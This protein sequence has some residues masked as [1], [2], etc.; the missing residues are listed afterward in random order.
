[1]NV[2]S[3]STLLFDHVDKSYGSLQVLKDFHG[4]FVRGRIAAIV[5]PNGAGKTTLLRIAAGLQSPTNGAVIKSGGLYYGGFDLLPRKGCVDDLRHALGLQPVR[6]GDRK[7]SV[8]SRGELQQA[9]LDAAF[10][11]DPEVLLLDEPWTALEPDA[12]E[13]LNIRMRDASFSHIIVCSSHDLDEV[14]RVADDVVFLAH[15]A[16]T[17]KRRESAGS[18]DRADLLNTYR[19]SKRS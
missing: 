17:W 13:A 11:L 18:F 19:E 4:T 14:V 9:G 15:G 1:M 2:A 16:A 10:D 8:L 3:L 7:L 5:G 6:Q 12:R